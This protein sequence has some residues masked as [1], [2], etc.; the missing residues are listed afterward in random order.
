MTMS[1]PAIS[2]A[3][4]GA[5]QAANPDWAAANTAQSETSPTQLISF[6]IGQ[7]VI[8]CE[9]DF[10]ANIDLTITNVKTNLAAHGISY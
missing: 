3:N 1:E 9:P 2:S 8:L 5:G 10:A 7:G 6:A 4:S